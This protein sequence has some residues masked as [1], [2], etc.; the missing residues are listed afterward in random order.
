MRLALET[1]C[2][3]KASVTPKMVARVPALTPLI[4]VHIRSA[5]DEFP[6]SDDALARARQCSSPGTRDSAGIQ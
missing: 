2:L 5:L 1:D 6:E 3:T 4:N